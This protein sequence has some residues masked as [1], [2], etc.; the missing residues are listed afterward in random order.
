M[1]RRNPSPRELVSVLL[2]LAE[3]EG[4]D[5]ELEQFLVAHGP[6]VAEAL[7]TTTTELD[8]VRSGE[9]RVAHYHAL[10]RQARE[11]SRDAHAEAMRNLSLAAATMLSELAR[12]HDDHVQLDAKIVLGNNLL[13]DCSS[14]YL[15]FDAEGFEP[16]NVL[17]SKLRD[18]SKVLRFSDL[19]ASL[20]R[21]ALCFGWRA[22][23]GGL[24]LISQEVQRR[25]RDAV[26]HVVIARPRPK[27]MELP[28]V[29]VRLQR[30]S[31]WIRDIFDALGPP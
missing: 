3:S 28:I 14:K 30:P 5:Q 18:V 27:P 19:Q 26:L 11:R 17:R 2:A 9:G 10:V 6:V 20:A 1:R 16:V 15:R 24:R 12:W 25:D 21:G 13:A 7:G 23:K 22:G 4:S 31:S 29:D 8:R